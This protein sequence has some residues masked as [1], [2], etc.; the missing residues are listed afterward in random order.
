M[1]LVIHGLRNIII[2]F[3]RVVVIFLYPE[4]CNSV[5]FVFLLLNH[6][7]QQNKTPHEGPRDKKNEDKLFSKKIRK[8]IQ[9]EENSFQVSRHFKTEERLKN[10]KKNCKIYT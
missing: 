1:F 5:G 8:N 2:V 6:V 3:I 9:I 7:I 10:D 4:S